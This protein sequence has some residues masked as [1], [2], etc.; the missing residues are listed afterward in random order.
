MSRR[1][2]LLALVALFAGACGTD[3]PGTPA[4]NN[5]DGECEDECVLGDR[6]CMDANT[7]EVCLR[8]PLT[9]C[10]ALERRVCA[11]DETCTDN[12]CLGVPKT[13]EDT[14]QAPAN[15]CNSMGQS[16][17]CADHNEDGCLEFGSAAACQAGEYCDSADGLC[18]QSEC[19]DECEESATACLEGLLST[20]TRNPQGCLVFGAGKECEAGKA[21][22][23]GACVTSTACEDE[24]EGEETICSPNGVLTCGNYDSDSCSEFSSAV[25]C[26][27]GEECRAGECVATTTCQ[28]GCLANE[29]V[30]VGNQI[31]RCETQTD[32][33]LAFSPP[34]ACPGTETCVSGGGTTMCEAPAVTGKVVINEIFYDA[35]GD[36]VRSNGT[37]PTFIELFGPPGLSIADFEIQLVNGSGGATYGTFTLPAGAQLDGNGFA[38]IGMETP[39]NFLSFIP[40]N[41][42]FIMTSYGGGQDGIQNGPDNVKLLDVSDQVVDAVGYGTFAGT[43]VFEGEGSAAPSSTS[44][45]SI[46]RTNGADT[47]DN[48]ADFLTFYPTPGIP[49][50]DLRINEVYFDQPGTDTGSETFVEVVAPIQGWEDIALDG[51]VLRAINGLNGNDYIFTFD[52]NGTAVVDGVDFSGYNLNEG[53]NSG[54]VVVCNIDTASNALLNRCTVPFEGSDFQNGPDNFVLEFNGRV[55][56][57]IG[58]GS[59]SAS[60]TFVGEGSAKSF[61]TSSAGKSLSRWPISD[62]SVVGDTN[63]NSVDFHLMTPSPASDNSP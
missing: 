22:E 41:K 9:G 6:S 19:V 14:C 18:K 16:E 55:V 15:R 13:C 37:S 43:S 53:I 61:S 49:N 31:S 57:A 7:V 60:D 24:C 3:D 58:Y 33:C 51:Y 30:C 26:S 45:R 2:L 42:Y 54:Y 63:D 39:D 35:A 4:P 40:T 34:A 10:F 12:D 62:P 21:C 20:C 27:A 52:E 17:T 50:A 47:D 5:V 1:F 8:N 48:S 36:D 23:E 28:D 32:G 11:M 25:A 44:G 46:G 38:I 56:D 59:F 29:A